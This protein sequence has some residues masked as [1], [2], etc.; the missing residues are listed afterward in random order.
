MAIFTGTS[1]NDSYLATPEGDSAIG[2]AGNDSLYGNS[3][4]DILNGNAD[5]DILFADSLTQTA[6]GNDSLFGGQ[7]NDTL[8]GARFGFSADSLG[9]NR[10]K[11]LLIASTNGGNTLFGGQG[12]DTIYGSVQNGNLMNGNLGNDLLIAGRGRDRMLGADGNDT[13]IGGSDNNDM[14]GEDGDDEFQF[15]TAISGDLT[16]FVGAEQVVRDRGGFGGSDI[17]NDF[18]TGDTI[19]ISELDRN[20]TIKVS[21]NSAGA[22][23]IE[24]NGTAGSS[25]GNSQP[26]T[27]TITAIGVTREQ[28]LAPGSQNLAINGQFITSVDTANTDTT[29]TY[30]VGNG[31]SGG[32]IQG[33]I[34]VG[35]TIG[36]SFSPN[37]G[38]ATSANGFKL[39]TTNNDDVLTGNDGSDF[40]DGGTGNDSIDGGSGADTLVGNKGIDTLTG[41]S[42]SDF[43]QF[44]NFTPGEVDEITDYIPTPLVGAGVPA[45]VI[46]ISASAFGASLVAGGLPGTNFSVSVGIG[47]PNPN[48]VVPIGIAAFYF[49][50]SNGGGVYIDRDGGGTGTSFVKFARLLDLPLISIPIT[51]GAPGIGG[52]P[53]IEIIA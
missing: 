3:G 46:Q 43:F 37:S 1:A 32:D 41:G 5:D 40:M 19:N 23:V 53:A 18:S 13:L 28:L 27:N 44:V 35:T 12:N 51:G 42:G 7:G 20:A 21:T 9:G 4:S 45:D 34:L 2:L 15:F 48:L 24:I 16:A 39:V 29:S 6:G 25:L 38:I 22:T 14:F 31:K 33:K 8:V 52:L 17:I 36:D 30:T 50:L 26:A 11:D 49:D 47:Q 10:G